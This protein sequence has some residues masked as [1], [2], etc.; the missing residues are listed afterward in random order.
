MDEST[1]IGGN[2]KYLC[3]IISSVRTVR[4]LKESVAKC[5]LISGGIPSY[6]ANAL[7][8]FWPNFSAS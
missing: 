3:L 6:S 2:F 5:D 4:K 8:S 1:P 7:H